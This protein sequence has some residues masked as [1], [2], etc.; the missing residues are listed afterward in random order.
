M[1]CFSPLYLAALQCKLPSLCSASVSRAFILESTVFVKAVTTQGISWE[2]ARMSSMKE[3]QLQKYGTVVMLFI[4]Q[5]QI[6]GLDVDSRP[7]TEVCSTHTI[8]PG[9]KGE[10]YKLANT[11]ARASQICFI[12]NRDIMG[13][14]YAQDIHFCWAGEERSSTE[15]GAKT[16]QA[17]FW[18]GKG[19]VLRRD[20]CM[21]FWSSCY[22]LPHI[23][24]WY[25]SLAQFF[26]ATL[27]L[28]CS[29]SVF[30]LH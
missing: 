6:F 15:D 7:T 9:P 27:D 20:N 24:I 10:E 17:E 18:G 26:P 2:T 19:A 21:I 5:V 4:F 29:F 3:Q 23:Y 14:G 22:N 1:I 8:L 28:S 13:L 25:R 12:L 30:Y 11:K 16:W